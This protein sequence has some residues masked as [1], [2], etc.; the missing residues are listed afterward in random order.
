METWPFTGVPPNPTA[1]ILQTARNRAIDQ[2]R[3][4]GVW[5]GKQENFVPLMEDCL[6]SGAS[7]RR[8]PRFEDEIPTASCG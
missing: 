5:R 6:E 1:W 3:R 2:T 7:P 8:P 4:S